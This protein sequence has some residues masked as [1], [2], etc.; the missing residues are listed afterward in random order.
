LLVALEIITPG[1]RKISLCDLLPLW[2]KNGHS[3]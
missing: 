3:L 1:E 2:Q